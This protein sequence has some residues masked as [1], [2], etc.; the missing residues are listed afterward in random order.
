MPWENESQ[1][2]VGEPQKCM[3]GIEAARKT[4]SVENSVV[5]FNDNAPQTAEAKAAT[6]LDLF[7]NEN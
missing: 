2:F 3:K 5:I 7:V 1:V 6:A 4:I